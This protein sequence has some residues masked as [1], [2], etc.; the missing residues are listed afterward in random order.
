MKCLA[1]GLTESVTEY[2]LP[3]FTSKV[4]QSRKFCLAKST[5]LQTLSW[6]AASREGESKRMLFKQ[7]ATRKKQ[8]STPS[9][10]ITRDPSPATPCCRAGAEEL[11]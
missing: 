8:N 9:N 4:F 7:G 2:Q 6:R 11:C 3:I 5:G 10:E 1:R